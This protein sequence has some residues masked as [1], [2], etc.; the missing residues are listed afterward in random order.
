M[1]TVCLSTVCSAKRIA[2][3]AQSSAGSDTFPQESNDDADILKW[4][5]LFDEKPHRQIAKTRRAAA[6]GSHRLR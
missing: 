4:V 3:L 2:V 1:S 6:V 5:A